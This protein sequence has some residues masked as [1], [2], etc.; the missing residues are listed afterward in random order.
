[1]HT[2]Y[3]S[4]KQ[5]QSLGRVFSRS[6]FLKGIRQNGFTTIYRLMLQPCQLEND[7]NDID[8]LKWTKDSYLVSNAPIELFV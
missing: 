3:L 8:L 4:S 2:H 6:T 1:M 5:P 7:F